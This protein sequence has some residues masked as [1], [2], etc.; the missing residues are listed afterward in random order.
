MLN[1]QEICE[2]IAE[3]EKQKNHTLGEYNLLSALY[4]IRDHAFG[5]SDQQYSAYSRAAE[6]VKTAEA[7]DRYGDSDFLVAVYG[8]MPDAAWKVM[9][10]LMDTL[11][12]ANPRLYES[13][14]RKIKQL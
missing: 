10:S 6:P 5:E 3:L 2:Y 4:S 13:F 1:E 8:K 12:V 14:M 7:L 9:D 11:Q